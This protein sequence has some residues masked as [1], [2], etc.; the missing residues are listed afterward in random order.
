MVLPTC[1]ENSDP[2]CGRRPADGA[3]LP[4]DSPAP[5]IVPV[6]PPSLPPEPEQERLSPGTQQFA[7]VTDAWEQRSGSTARGGG[8]GSNV[9]GGGARPGPGRDCSSDAAGSSPPAEGGFTA[10]SSLAAEDNPTSGKGSNP[11]QHRRHDFC[12]E[13]M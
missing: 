5:R 12:L 4:A 1:S 10:G 3:E 8:G 11:L 13:I 7:A 2:L 6:G 9:G